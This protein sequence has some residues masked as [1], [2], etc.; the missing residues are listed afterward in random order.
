MQY[1]D[2]L[3]TSFST[4]EGKALSSTV[5][6]CVQLK[7]EKNKLFEIIVPKDKNPCLS[8]RVIDLKTPKL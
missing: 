4:S 1:L 6:N 7:L 3:E 5:L 8:G 2:A